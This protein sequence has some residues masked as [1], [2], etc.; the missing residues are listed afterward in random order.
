M[1]VHG[2]MQQL[3]DFLQGMQCTVIYDVLKSHSQI[4]DRSQSPI[5]SLYI[6]S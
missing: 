5:M 6:T 1:F 4:R 3:G 2:G